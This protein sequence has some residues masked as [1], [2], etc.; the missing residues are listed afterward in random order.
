[1]KHVSV[2]YLFVELIITGQNRSNHFSEFPRPSFCS[3][4]LCRSQQGSPASLQPWAAHSA[5]PHTGVQVE[6]SAAEQ[7]WLV[8]W[9][10]ISGIKL[11]K[12]SKFCI[13]SF[14]LI[15]AYNRTLGTILLL[16]LNGMVFRFVF[17]L[18]NQWSVN[19]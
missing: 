9:E 5:V 11:D 6:G 14:H 1:M 18:I 3:I 13:F 8:Y 19:L 16:F 7:A 10:T 17:Y 4:C 15:S 12:S 2:N